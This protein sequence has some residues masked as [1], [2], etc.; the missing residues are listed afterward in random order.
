[1]S[2]SRDQSV[3]FLTIPSIGMFFFIQSFDSIIR[4][5]SKLN[6]VWNSI[7]IPPHQ[8]VK[9]KLQF[10]VIRESLK[11]TSGLME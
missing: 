3:L 1:M 5:I 9:G 4:L 8:T 7:T 2:I 11:I 6:F 10:N